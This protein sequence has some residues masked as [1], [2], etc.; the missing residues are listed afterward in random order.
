MP[1]TFLSQPFTNGNVKGNPGPR[2]T[3]RLQRYSGNILNITRCCT[4]TYDG[5]VQYGSQ[6]LAHLGEVRHTQL[7]YCMHGNNRM[8]HAFIVEICCVQEQELR[9]TLGSEMIDIADR[10]HSTGLSYWL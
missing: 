9:R 6:F 10:L 7:N 8:Q 5:I 4:T 1:V 2:E 3:T